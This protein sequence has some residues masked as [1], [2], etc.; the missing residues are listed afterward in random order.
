MS[1]YNLIVRRHKGEDWSAWCNT[2]DEDILKHNINA[3]E[4]NGW[5][6]SLE[7]PMTPNTF[8]TTCYAMGIDN[9][10]IQAYCIGK[11]KFVSDDIEELRRRATNG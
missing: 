11:T 8:K 1:K 4:N 6:W 7:T 2:N 3:V 9:N 10:L 5:L